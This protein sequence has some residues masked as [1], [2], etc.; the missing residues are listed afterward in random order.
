MSVKA[1][2]EDMNLSLSTVHHAT[3]RIGTNGLESGRSR[4]GRKKKLSDV[5][6]ASIVREVKKN[7]RITIKGIQEIT[8][9]RSVSRET[10]RKAIVKDGRFFGGLV[11]ARPYINECNRKKRVK[12]CKKYLHWSVDDWK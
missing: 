1:I 2:A 9:L 4:S 8:G 7:R 5:D 10:I 11:T 12:W 6:K 3:V